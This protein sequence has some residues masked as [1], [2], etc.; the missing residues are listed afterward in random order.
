MKLYEFYLSKWW[1]LNIFSRFS[2]NKVKLAFPLQPWECENAKWHLLPAAWTFVCPRFSCLVLNSSFGPRGTHQDAASC[3]NGQRDQYCP[4][5]QLSSIPNKD[6]CAW[7]R[8][9][10]SRVQ[11][12]CGA[13]DRHEKNIEQSVD[14]VLCNINDFLAIF[15]SRIHFCFPIKWRRDKHREFFFKK[16]KEKKRNGKMIDEH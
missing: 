1:N 15:Q 2:V 9:E 10:I 6:F 7:W 14:C 8:K 13:L 11:E 5:H 16:K 3:E 12:T 4:S